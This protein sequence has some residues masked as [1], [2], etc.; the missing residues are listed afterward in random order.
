MSL[1]FENYFSSQI[2]KAVKDIGFESLSEVQKNS[3]PPILEGK[4]IICQ[5]ETGSG[6]TA[7]FSL[8]I[9]EKIKG[10]DSLSALILTPTR[11]LNLQ[12]SNEIKK[13]IKYRKD[14]SVVSIYG[15]DSIRGQLKD[16]R[17][18]PSI[19]VA[20]PGRLIDFLN[21]GKINLSFLKFIVLDEADEMFDMGFR[22]DI[23]NIFSYLNED[24]QKLFFS[25]TMPKV[26]LD[27]IKKYLKNPEIIKLR[28]KTLTSSSVDENYM[29]IEEIEK[30]EVINRVLYLYR[31]NKAIIFS[32]TKEKTRQIA[33][34]LIENSYKALAL[35]GDL[36]QENRKKV[37]DSFRC[38]STNVLVA[39]DVAA[40]GL[41]ISDVDL[42][43]NYDIPQS[44]EYYV[45][46]IGRTGR[47]GKEGM[48]ISFVRK[49]DS[50]AI[51]NIRNITKNDMRQL[52]VPSRNKLKEI[53]IEKLTELIHK[54]PKDELQSI[55]YLL[56]KFSAIEIASALI[57][58]YMKD[59]EKKFKNLEYVDD[60]KKRRNR[61]KEIRKSKVRIFAN[62][63][64][65]D[66]ISKAE[67]LKF[68]IEKGRLPKEAFGTID[69]LRSFS[70]IDVDK[71]YSKN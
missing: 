35:N 2:V 12:L 39:T 36:K 62:F 70:F 28:K 41:D 7:A 66:N 25:A 68:L 48:A 57:S 42:V 44:P 46:R 31:P 60:G 22:E 27:F 43:I 61:K 24:V 18:K 32:N 14:L 45:H 50:R 55:N 6:K 3:I 53:Q 8:P 40:R 64:K 30:N 5:A 54:T 34:Y 65:R 69:L 11:E 38:G 17:K 20:T 23:E 21:R 10:E 56:E 29:Q 67:V 33:D 59:S 13:F 51:S 63:G 4:D 26:I 58:H 1:E 19:V 37:M 49:R 47:F 15:G 16:L 71:A 52:E 9:I